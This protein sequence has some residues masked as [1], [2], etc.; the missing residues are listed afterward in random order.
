[1]PEIKFH[2]VKAA[3]YREVPVHG[4]FGGLTPNARGLFVSVYSERAAIP[5]VIANEISTEGVLGDEIASAREGKEGVVRLVHF[6]M[7]MSIDEAQALRDWLTSKLDE[8]NSVMEANGQSTD[9]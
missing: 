6:G 2:F 3:D 4:A 7:H 8:F 1:M 9:T 5:Q